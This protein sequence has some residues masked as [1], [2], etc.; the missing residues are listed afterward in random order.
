M[1]SA[2]QRLCLDMAFVMEGAGS[3]ACTAAAS[4]GSG[5]SLVNGFSAH[6]LDLK[7]CADIQGWFGWDANANKQGT[8]NLKWW[9]ICSSSLKAGLWTGDTQ[10]L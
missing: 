4:T 5:G 6:L 2:V 1:N 10:S 9:H 7:G 8:S 3:P